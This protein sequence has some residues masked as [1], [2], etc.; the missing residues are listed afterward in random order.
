MCVLFK[1]TAEDLSAFNIHSLEKS[2]VSSCAVL[3]KR[4]VKV[5]FQICTMVSIKI[6]TLWDSALYSLI[7]IDPHFTFA[8]CLHHQGTKPKRWL[9][10]T[11]Y[12]QC[13]VLE[14]SHLHVCKVIHFCIVF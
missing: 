3:G 11:A 4:L 9:V 12:T 6:T 1:G 7:V 5:R 2:G 14:N 10:S 13:S 8:Y